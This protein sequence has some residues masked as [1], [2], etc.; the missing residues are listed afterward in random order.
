[1]FSFA[2]WQMICKCYDELKNPKVDMPIII[3]CKYLKLF[4]TFIKLSKDIRSFRQQ[5]LPLWHRFDLK[6]NPALGVHNLAS[7]ITSLVKLQ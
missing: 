5:R 7:N 4:L 6:T 1:M 3:T 2:G